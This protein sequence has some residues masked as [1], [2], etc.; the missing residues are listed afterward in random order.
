MSKSTYNK[1]AEIKKKE[2]RRAKKLYK[3]GE[4][5]NGVPR[6]RSVSGWRR[7]KKKFPACQEFKFGLR[8]TMLMAADRAK[9]KLKNAAARVLGAR[10]HEIPETDE[11]TCDGFIERARTLEKSLYIHNKI[12]PNQKRDEPA[13]MTFAQALGERPATVSNLTN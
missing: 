6:P 12:Y 8:D 9:S 11:D 2:K 3:Q 1:R 10:T 5:C 13:V 4:C 7:H